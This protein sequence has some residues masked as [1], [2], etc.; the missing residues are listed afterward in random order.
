MVIVHEIG[1]RSGE[2]NALVNLGLA[3]DAL[4][5]FR[6]SIEFQDWRLAIAREIGDQRGEANALWNSALSFEQLFDR[7]KAT[8]KA[9]AALKFYEAIESPFA[10]KVRQGCLSGGMSVVR[11]FSPGTTLHSSRCCAYSVSKQIIRA[12]RAGSACARVSRRRRICVIALPSTRR[13]QVMAGSLPAS[14]SLSS[15]KGSLKAIL[16]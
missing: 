4:G 1:D 11:G 10:A 16:R 14:G 7:A 3:H 2:G 5:E 15:A 9:E 13:E 8:V 6:K 12:R